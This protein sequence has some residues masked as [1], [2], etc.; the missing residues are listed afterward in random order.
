EVALGRTLMVKVPLLA[1][2]LLALP[3]AAGAG[4]GD[5]KADAAKARQQ[6]ID[7]TNKHRAADRAP[8]VKRNATLMTVAQQHAENMARQEKM[9]HL[10]DGKTSKERA[11]EAGYPGVVGENVYLS[12]RPEAGAAAEDA[13]RGWLKSPSHRA[14]LLEK[15]YT[16]LGTGMARSKRGRWY[17]C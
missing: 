13:I 5:D 15:T 6:I 16:E 17:L 11:R 8:A 1:V 10:L 14:N 9:A 4:A 7:L 3:L 12:I 2:S